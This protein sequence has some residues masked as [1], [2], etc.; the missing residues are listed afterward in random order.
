MYK[1]I[2]QRVS[3]TWASVSLSALV[4]GL[5]LIIVCI[6]TILNIVD[7]NTQAVTSSRLTVNDTVVKNYDIAYPAFHVEKVDQILRNYATR[8]VEEFWHELGDKKNDPRHFLTL[9]YTIL[10]YGATTVSVIFHEQ[11]QF[12][13]K[14]PI[15]SQQR[16]TLDLKEQKRL[17][18][19]DIFKDKPAA[20]ALLGR[21]LHDY[22]ANE[23]N[24]QFPSADLQQYQHF[25]L[26]LIKDFNLTQD[27]VVLYFNP[28]E[29]SSPQDTQAIAIKRDLLRDIL[30]PSYVAADPDKVK[31][32]AVQPAYSIV[33]LPRRSATVDP[34]GKMLALTF[35]DGP[36][37]LTSRLLDVLKQYDARA[38]FFVIGRQVS[39]YAGEM[40]RMAAEGHEIGNHTWDHPNLT[41][42][43]ASEIQ[44]QFDLTQQAVQ[45]ATGGYTPVL[46]RPPMGMVNDTVA[47]LSAARGMAVTLWSV[48]PKDWLNRNANFVYNQI[49]SSAADNRI[50]L[51]HDI[52]PTSVDAAIRAIADLRG[53]GYQLVT[54][55]ELNH[56]R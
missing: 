49:M 14:P 20:A 13:D 33:K 7:E 15:A 27:A 11:K 2:K 6:I 31:N 53:Q 34:S 44:R 26:D 1:T 3:A 10:H 25:T 16:L 52:H 41:L 48:D 12:Y 35:D 19:N 17:A 9:K 8:Q 18:F 55:S 5:L 46:M 50:I 37:S 40:K 45:Q 56:Y 30:R 23:T 4:V 32:E 24:G 43:S 38:T 28:H 51:L 36:G 29:P 21:L 54:V 42:L 22:F 39:G 47:T